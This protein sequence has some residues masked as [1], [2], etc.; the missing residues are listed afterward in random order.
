M[1]NSLVSICILTHNNEDTIEKCL[2]SC[3]NQT[4]KNIEIVIVDN[5]STDNTI[6]IIN[7]FD[8]N[9]IPYRLIENIENSL[10]GGRNLLY[11]MSIGDYI[12]NLD[13]DDTLISDCINI[14]T[15]ILDNN[16]FLGVV[17]SNFE[18]EYQVIQNHFRQMGELINNGKLKQYQLIDSLFACLGTIMIRREVLD[19][20]P[21][22]E[23][24]IYEKYFGIGNG[25][26]DQIFL[27]Y[28]YLNNVNFY[29]IDL[30]LYNYIPRNTYNNVENKPSF[31]S[32]LRTKYKMS[33]KDF[34]KY[35]YTKRLDEFIITSN[36]S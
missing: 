36:V 31:I 28:L 5:C 34:L 30:P 1:K 23:Y 4:Y 16:D 9:D 33:N 20:F 13:G 7:N 6:S 35:V 2:T 17:C 15:Q 8:F 29:Y 10:T 22:N 21:T 11:N 25:G 19:L 3:I 24:F 26:E 27:S 32:K 18:S 14:K 12:Q